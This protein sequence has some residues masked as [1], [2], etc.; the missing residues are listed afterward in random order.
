MVNL[1]LKSQLNMQ[2]LMPYYLMFYAVPTQCFYCNLMPYCLVFCCSNLM[3]YELK[4]WGK[5][6]HMGRHLIGRDAA[7]AG[8]T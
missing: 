7:G 4:F 2:N 5:Y 8:R 3:L 6:V 1:I